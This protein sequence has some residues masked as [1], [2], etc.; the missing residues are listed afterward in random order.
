[1]FYSIIPIVFLILLMIGYR[2]IGP[3]RLVITIGA[4]G[5]TLII[6][7]II[8]V[9]PLEAIASIAGLMIASIWFRRLV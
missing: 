5:M 9:P 3:E 2:R 7:L 8:G 1:M 4:A 6:L